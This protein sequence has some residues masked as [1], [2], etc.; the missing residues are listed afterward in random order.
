MDMWLLI[1]L[2]IVGIILL[3]ALFEKFSSQ[4]RADGIFAEWMRESEVDARVR[5][6]ALTLLNNDE[7]TAQRLLASLRDRY[8]DKTEQ[9]YWE[10]M[11]YDLERDR[12]I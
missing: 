11:L 4:S 12:T 5:R 9:W 7:P 6:R 10:K 3:Y 2:V 8:P 1:L